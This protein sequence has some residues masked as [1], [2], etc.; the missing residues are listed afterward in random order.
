MGK[1]KTENK[2]VVFLFTDSL[3]LSFNSKIN[4]CKCIAH[5]RSK[6][7]QMTTN[8]RLCV[9]QSWNSKESLVNGLREDLGT[10][11]LVM[12]CLPSRYSRTLCATPVRVATGDKWKNP[13]KNCQGGG[14]P[15]NLHQG[16]ASDAHPSNRVRS[17]SLSLLIRR[18]GCRRKIACNLRERPT[19]AS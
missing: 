16:R 7:G 19:S 2:G 5:S 13:V 8:L 11:Q 12:T 1:F 18:S 15:A 14:P 6:S 9:G 17:C 3:V 10:T 4:D